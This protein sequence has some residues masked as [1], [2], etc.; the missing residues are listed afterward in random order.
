MTL[1]ASDSAQ[2]AP[3]GP[4]RR[5]RGGGGG[6]SSLVMPRARLCSRARPDPPDAAFPRKGSGAGASPADGRAWGLPGGEGERE[7]GKERGR[8]RGRGG[9]GEGEGGRGRGRARSHFGSR[10]S[11]CSSGRL[12]TRRLLAPVHRPLRGSSPAP[13]AM[14]LWQTFAPGSGRPGRYRQRSKPGY[15]QQRAAPITCPSCLASQP[16]G[17][18]HCGECGEVLP[19]PRPVAASPS[20]AERWL[21]QSAQPAA[22]GKS[23]LSKEGYPEAPW[24]RQAPAARP[25]ADQPGP[26]RHR[27]RPRRRPLALRQWART[28]CKVASPPGRPLWATSSYQMGSEQGFPAH[29]LAPIQAMAQAAK[30][31]WEGLRPLPVRASAA[32]AKAVALEGKATKQAAALLKAQPQEAAHVARREHVRLQTELAAAR[33]ESALVEGQLAAAQ[34]PAPDPVEEQPD[35]DG[36][37]VDGHRVRGVA[38]GRVPERAPRQRGLRCFAYH[39]SPGSAAAI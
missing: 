17:Q 23:A 6:A 34:P 30:E 28:R 38:A 8:G 1:G 29:A 27:L 19:K 25:A 12:L 5:R 36:W 31:R 15:G 26:L 10:C 4:P 11:T 2:V 37:M 35:S 21:S 13:S 18:R 22:V 3:P 20:L 7:R 33:Q 14:S 9:E 16:A 32:R 39:G 24:H